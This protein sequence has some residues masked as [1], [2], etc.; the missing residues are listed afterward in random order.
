MRVLRTDISRAKRTAAA[1]FALGLCLTL[2]T[3][4]APHAQRRQ[5]QG[6]NVTGVSSRATERGAVV[7]ITGDAPLTRAQT[8]QDDEG[9]HIVGYKWS[10]RSGTPRGVKVR[11][12]G[13]S[14]EMVI[15]VRRGGSVS[16]H[17][18]FNSLDIVVNG[19]LESPPTATRSIPRTVRRSARR[20]RRSPR[21][22]ERES[23]RGR[24][25]VGRPTSSHT[26]HQGRA[27]R[28][29]GAS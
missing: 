7:S 1:V 8:W 26:S 6:A 28:E 25:T 20:P 11:R 15:P 16:V 5:E 17:P 14:T 19:G 10:M 23:R 2:F 9:F 21:V 13:D 27:E 4:F 3:P 18:R 12:V 22:D 24:Q 29:A